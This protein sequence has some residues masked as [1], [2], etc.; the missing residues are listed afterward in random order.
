M[1]IRHSGA[2]LFVCDEC[3]ATWFVESEIGMKPFVDLGS[4]LQSL[5]LA[6]TWDELDAR[7]P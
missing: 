7:T 4:H 5:G 6:P 2:G 3:D 1:A